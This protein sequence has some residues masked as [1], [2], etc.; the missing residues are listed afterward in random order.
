[1]TLLAKPAIAIAL[2]GW[3]MEL[4]RARLKEAAPDRDIVVLR[5]LDQALPERYHLLCWKPD[6]RLLARSPAPLL[7]VSAGAGVD[8]I[9]QHGPPEGVPIARIVDADLTGRMAEYVALHCLFH[10]RRMDEAAACQTL[11]RWQAGPFA[12]AHE[13]CV[14]LM[15][16]G[17]MG[18]GAAKGLMALGFNVIGWGRTPRSGLPFETFAGGGQLDIFLQRT[19]IL[20]SLL[21]ATPQTCGLIDG[22]LL[23]RLRRS[24][25]FGAPVFISAGR[26]ANV[27][28]ADLVCALRDGTLRAASLDVFATEPLPAESPLWGMSNV[29]ITPHN[30][31][32][33]D[34]A[35]VAAAVMAEIDRFEA[36]LPM[37]HRVDR[38]RGY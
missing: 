14:G 34:P 18:Q 16:V 25:R 3:D 22:A 2:T 15:G 38:A 7:I 23:C 21:P 36:G 28:E 6:A 37:L 35:A 10:L 26:G 31:A 20:V 19:D 13:V 8:H 1:M 11:R 30:A 27:N 9:L 24:V 5:T 17:E 29:V 4:W 32:D 12:A 33:S